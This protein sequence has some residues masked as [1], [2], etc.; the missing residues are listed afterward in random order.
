VGPD[1]LLVFGQRTRGGLP[2]RGASLRLY[3]GAD[4]R[5]LHDCRDAMDAD[6]D[7]TVAIIDAIHTLMFLFA[8]GAPPA[9]PFPG[10]GF[11]RNEDDLCCKDLACKQ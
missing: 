4:G 5:L 2:V 10:C 7:G 1:W 11:D 8:G 3:L 9:P 6:D